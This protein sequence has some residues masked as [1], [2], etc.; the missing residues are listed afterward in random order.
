MDSGNRR[1]R[2][3]LTV[4]PAC[5]VAWGL[6]E[7]A[8]VSAGVEAWRVNEVE[9][10][11]VELYAPPT[12]VADTCFFPGTVLE[13][14]D[15]AGVVRAS[16][17]PFGVVT[18]FAG[19]TYFV[20]ATADSGIGADASLPFAL[21][22]AGG[23]VCLRS[24]ALRYDCV[25]WG[26]VSQAVVDQSGPD[27]NSV[28]PAIAAGQALVRIGDTD[29]VVDDFELGAPTPRGPNDGTPWFPPDAGPDAGTADAGAVDGGVVEEDAGDLADAS[30]RPDARLEPPAWL[31]AEPGGG[32]CRASGEGAGAAWLVLLALAGLSRRRGQDRLCGGVE[33]AR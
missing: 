17:Q 25:R 12:R 31:H 8:P 10:R 28:A 6:L 32:G 16:V 29:V 2:L 20:F 30:T 1:G 14:L 21:D 5:T 11:Y 22:A 13:L 24:G 15:G 26:A 9:P 7:S 18:C 4:V 23:Q 19:D 3:A 27:D 33:P